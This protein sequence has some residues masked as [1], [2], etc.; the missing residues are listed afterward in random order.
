MFRS[1]SGSETRKLLKDIS[2]STFGEEEEECGLRR[3]KRHWSLLR[4]PSGKDHTTSQT[5]LFISKDSE[6]GRD[7]RRGCLDKNR[8]DS[9]FPADSKEPVSS[10][11]PETLECKVLE[12][13]GERCQPTYE[14]KNGEDDQGNSLSA[15]LVTAPVFWRITCYL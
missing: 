3:E 6:S 15:L 8:I 13:L 10:K 7:H 4:P 2:N 9:L 11:P 1:N 5:L 14:N 12:S